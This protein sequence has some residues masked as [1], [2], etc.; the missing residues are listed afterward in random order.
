MTGTYRGVY[1]KWGKKNIHDTY[2][3]VQK[4]EKKT[5]KE[6]LRERVPVHGRMRRRKKENERQREN[7][8]KKEDPDEKDRKTNK[9]GKKTP[10]K[11]L[12]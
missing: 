4:S 10:T 2:M 7:A 9:D 6:N 11:Y 12:R 8:W 5:T 1:I 3:G